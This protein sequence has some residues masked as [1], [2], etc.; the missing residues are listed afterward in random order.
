LELYTRKLLSISSTLRLEHIAS[1]TNPGFV[2]DIN[3]RTQSGLLHIRYHTFQHM[4]NNF[5]S[6]F[7]IHI[8]LTN[9]QENYIRHI[10][11]RHSNICNS[12]RP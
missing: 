12:W 3:L 5:S 11:G 1:S 2:P 6:T 8:R 10:H 7:T 9:I 4:V